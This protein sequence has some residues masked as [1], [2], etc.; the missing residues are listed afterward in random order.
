MT[1]SIDVVVV[2]EN[3]FVIV[4]LPDFSLPCRS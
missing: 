1:V 3:E 4:F 2:D